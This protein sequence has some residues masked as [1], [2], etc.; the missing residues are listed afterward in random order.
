MFRQEIDE[1]AGA[2]GLG[3]NEFYPDLPGIGFEG[4]ADMYAEMQKLSA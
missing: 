2:H 1:G 4:K 3:G